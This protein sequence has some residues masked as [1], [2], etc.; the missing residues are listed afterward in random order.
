MSSALGAAFR[1]VVEGESLDAAAMEAAIRAIMSGEC[2]PAQVAGFLVALRM[3]G[4]SSDE[5][6][7]A[8]RVL[9][10]LATPVDLSGLGPITD[11]VGTGG[12][13]ASTF[14][15]STAS[16]FVLAAAG[17]RV[18]KHG[19]RSVSS[20]SGAADVLEQAGARLA[21]APGEVRALIEATGFAFLFAPA[22]HGAMR[23]AIGVRRELG[24]RTLFNLL[25]PLSNPA[26]AG[27]GLIGVFAGRWVRPVAEVLASLGAAHVLVVHADDG[28]D[29]LSVA[30]PSRVVEVRGGELHEYRVDPAQL[31]VRRGD[32]AE[33]R[34]ASPLE[35][36]AMLERVLR[37]RDAGVPTD[38]VALNAG[39]ALYAADLA[40]D[41]TGGVRL[42]REVLASGA[43]WERLGRYTEQSQIS[44][45]IAAT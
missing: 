32:L 5:I 18:A 41:L 26:G 7:A 21:L 38:L 13:G 2:P 29:E 31:G 33:A 40:T 10:T 4:E 24:V 6:A 35:S 23:H 3:K 34:V 15:V 27:H 39:A 43:A 45:S 16:A 22:F 11:I 44:A 8:A 19:N 9:R 17:A 1:R 36:L 25:G 37:G 20:S 42:A 28:L 14:N 12:D 30:A